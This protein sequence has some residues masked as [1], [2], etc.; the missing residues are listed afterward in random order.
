MTGQ[1]G[2]PPGPRNRQLLARAQ[3]PSC[4]VSMCC[5]NSS[6]EA[7]PRVFPGPCDRVGGTGFRRGHLPRGEKQS[8]CTNESGRGVRV[9]IPEQLV[10]AKLRSFPQSATGSPLRRKEG[11]GQVSSRMPAAALTCSDSPS[12]A[13]AAE[14]AKAA[15]GQGQLLATA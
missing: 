9:I 13:I 15:E 11:Q 12:R 2:G 10:T 8:F 6:H 14:R 3:L 5:P 4:C 7:A 1:S